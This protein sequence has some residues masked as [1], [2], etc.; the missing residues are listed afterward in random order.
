MSLTLAAG[1][2]TTHLN[3]SDI[4]ND[5]ELIAVQYNRYIAGTMTNSYNVRSWFVGYDD[6]YGGWGVIYGAATGYDYDCVLTKPCTDRDGYSDVIP[7][8]A[9]YY[10]LKPFR[11]IVSGSALVLTLELSWR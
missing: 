6:N 1:L 7:I 5:N 2:L 10:R 4:N 9:P 3:T 8:V 11:M